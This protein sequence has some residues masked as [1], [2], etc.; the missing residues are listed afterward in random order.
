MQTYTVYLIARESERVIAYGG[1]HVAWEDAHVTNV[2]V[3]PRF[4]GLGL[5]ERM[6]RELMARAGARGAQ[7]ITL[8]VR[9][10]NTAALNLYRKLGYITE[11]G[12][13]RKGYYADTLED[14]IVMWKDPI[15]D[16]EV[17]QA[18]EV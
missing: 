9:R 1:I 7:R 8:E 2:A 5:G 15:V 13:V 4:R 18:A 14:A 10:S 3:H 17:A 12:A 11:P 16:P 6:M